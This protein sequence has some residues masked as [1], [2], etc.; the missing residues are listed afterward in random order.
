MQRISVIG[1]AAG[2]KSTV[3]RALSETLAL[4]WHEIDRHIPID[5]A[6]WGPA[7]HEAFLAYHA[8][9]LAGAAWVIDGIGPLRRLDDLFGRADAIVHIDLP[10][11]QHVARAI[12]RFEAQRT[13]RIGTGEPGAPPPQSFEQLF[14]NIWGHH[15]S[16][17]PRV[18]K[19]IEAQAGRK[20]IF[21]LTSQAE[22]DGFLAGHCRSAGS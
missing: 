22:I 19:A 9:L 7:E 20:P 15:E 18:Q 14:R 11:E 8:G 3:A 10:I 1:N 4:P 21:N 2:G 12:A 5:V 16:I 6:V 13:E 17:R